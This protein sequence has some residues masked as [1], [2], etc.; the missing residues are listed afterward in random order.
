MDSDDIQGVRKLQT[1]QVSG[2]EKVNYAGLGL[3]PSKIQ[4]YQSVNRLS[5]VITAGLSSGPILA[6]LFVFPSKCPPEEH[7]DLFSA[8]KLHDNKEL[9]HILTKFY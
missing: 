9:G 7:F 8:N 3:V 2:T 6:L 5:E 1:L 4:P